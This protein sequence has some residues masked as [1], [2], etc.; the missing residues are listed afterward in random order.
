MKVNPV[1]VALGMA[2]AYRGLSLVGVVAI[3]DWTRAHDLARG[4][5]LMGALWA[6]AATTDFRRSGL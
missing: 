1:W 2:L 4:A 6:I 3:L 5:V